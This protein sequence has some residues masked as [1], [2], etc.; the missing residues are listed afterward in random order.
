M[1]F[2]QSIKAEVL[3]SVLNGDEICRFA[4]YLPEIAD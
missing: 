3:Q 1:I 4:I 2:G